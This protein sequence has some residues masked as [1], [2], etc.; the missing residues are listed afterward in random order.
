MAGAGVADVFGVGSR[1][2]RL[3]RNP[4]THVRFRTYCHPK[5]TKS[6]QSARPFGVLR[7]SWPNRL[8]GLVKAKNASWVSVLSWLAAGAFRG[9][10]EP[11]YLPRWLALV[12]PDWK[13]YDGW[14]APGTWGHR[15]WAVSREFVSD[16]LR[17]STPDG[18]AGPSVGVLSGGPGDH[19]QVACGRSFSGRLRIVR[20]A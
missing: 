14:T 2:G 5:Q 4:D 20:S 19:C 9:R 3:E 17:C 8:L 16:T 11:S 12:L 6:G 10:C 7:W 18:E 13:V 15:Q 1:V